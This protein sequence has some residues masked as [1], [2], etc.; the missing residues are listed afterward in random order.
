[1]AQVTRGG[2]RRM[3]KGLAQ[4]G[5]VAWRRLSWRRRAEPAFVILGAQRSGT[6]S[7]YRYLCSHPGI[8]PALRKEIHF[9]DD[10]FHR[11]VAWY[12]AHFPAAASLRRADGAPAI[13]GEGS[14]YYLF[15]PAVPGR[16][17]SVLRD[18]RLIAVLRNPID[19]AYS[20][21]HHE[22][23]MG[24]ETLPFEEA[25]DREPERL[26]GE[27]ERRLDGRT[28][29][30]RAHRSFSYL[31]RGVY[32][33]QLLAW[34]R[35]YPRERLLVLNHEEMISD[36]EPV[37]V[38]AFSFLGL[39]PGGGPF[40]RPSYPAY[41]VLPPQLRRKLETWFQPHNRRLFDHLGVRWEW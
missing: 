40:R 10:N 37:L 2:A 26:A 41:S 15:H 27:A 33:D 39:Q 31:S 18:V 23:R 5:V 20:H 1:V 38:R 25:V 14:P 9:F 34:E 16:M 29:I 3:A 7:L 24:R 17:S 22:V 13:T 28:R 35:A 6:S 8:V 30:S 11:G 36:P 32:V 21:Y 12:R 4:R 19:R